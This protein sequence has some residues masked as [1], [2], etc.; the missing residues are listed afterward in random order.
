[1]SSEKA[2]EQT[3]LATSSGAADVTSVGRCARSPCLAIGSTIL[4]IAIAV[5]FI[6]IWSQDPR[7]QAACGAPVEP[8][9]PAAKCGEQE[10]QSFA[11]EPEASL[12]RTLVLS[13]MQTATDVLAALAIANLTNLVLMNNE[14]ERVCNAKSGSMPGAACGMRCTE[15]MA[16]VRR[17][18]PPRSSSV[19]V[20]CIDR[21]NL[22]RGEGGFFEFVS[23]RYDQLSG[24]V[25]FSQSTLTNAEGRQQVVSDLVTRAGPDGPP[26]CNP[27]A[28]RTMC[29]GGLV[30]TSRE[31]SLFNPVGAPC[32][33]C[34]APPSTDAETCPMLCNLTLW[35]RT[36]KQ[37]SY[38]NVGRTA[39]AHRVPSRSQQGVPCAQRVDR[40]R[41]TVRAC[42]AGGPRLPEHDGRV[43]GGVCARAHGHR[44]PP[45]LPRVRAQHGQRHPPPAARALRAH[46]R[47]ADEV[48]QPRGLA[49][50]RARHAVHL[51]L[52]LSARG[53]G[54]RGK[55]A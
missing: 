9:E 51:R 41:C 2:T 4:V 42:S 45:V 12:N 36:F 38:P 11:A 24:V 39:D 25:V 32:S 34:E 23:E 22:G 15:L 30:E 26:A 35:D 16:E 44:R 55:H 14:A 47:R 19:H 40:S 53:R 13:G 5:V 50:R 31:F 10:W 43:A 6:V 49:L 46:P 52:R 18:S 7:L 27:D 3:P 28:L 20:E 48:R 54:G 21:K 17:S 33:S 1:M 37:R 29:P 8:F